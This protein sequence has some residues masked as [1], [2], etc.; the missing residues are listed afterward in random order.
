[1]FRPMALT[2]IFALVG[3]LA[4]ALTFV[5]VL[6]SL[7]LRKGSH[8]EPLTARIADRA[9]AWLSE[10]IIPRPRMVLGVTAALLAI[11]FAV[12][13]FLGTEFIPTLDEGTLNLD[14][15]RVPSISL[16]GAIA[17]ATRT[18]KV[19]KEVPE[20]T[21][22]ISRIG[23]S[24]LATDTAG[25]DES[26]VYVFL[27]P[28]DEWRFKDREELVDDIAARLSREVPE[29]RFGFSQPIENRLNDMI[30]G[31][32]GDVAIH[33]YGDNLDKMLETGREIFRVVSEI[34]GAADGKIAP[35]TGLPDLNI[36]IDRAAAARYGINVSDVLDTVETIGGRVSGQ[37][38]EG[39]ARYLLQVRFSGNS[40]ATAEQLDDI[41]VATPDGK[42]IP[43]A[44]LARF[45]SHEGPV[46]IW[47]EN[48]NRRVSVAM[49]VRGRDLGSFVAAAQAAVAEKVKL[50]HGWWLEWGG[51]YENLQRAAHRLMVL[52]PASLILILVLLY[53]TFTSMRT[54]ILIFGN[55]LAGGSGGILA[56]FLRGL[57]FSITAG[58]GFITLFGVSV[59]N[60]VVLVSEVNR[61]RQTGMRVRD[62]IAEAS[63][64]RL[65]PILMASM[66]AL[67]GFIPMAISHH[68]GAEIQRPLATVVIGGL[69]TST[70]F[71]LYV[72]P[73]L[74]SRLIKDVPEK[75]Q[76]PAEAV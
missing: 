36:E 39:N 66:V 52:V 14:V 32:K 42:L 12:A 3:S 76:E 23:H 19:L 51:Q 62:A 73:I 75:R 9:H 17:N 10:R 40:R 49:N 69:I 22:V 27:K 72:L 1:M 35:R 37:V 15:L 60:G 41:K 44:Q 5:P 71:T 16:D 4:C 47:R 8:A 24:E 74:F 25:P 43:L 70:P 68:A 67:F 28:R 46:S 50:P 20:V 11:S 45:S 55:V 31:I 29:D 13:P 33:I 54:A 26:D 64:S 30:A 18:E 56:L 38:V 48:L 58:V 34:P 61:L 57:T 53:N 6:A 59:L 65:R 21:R 7:Q 2:V 63:R